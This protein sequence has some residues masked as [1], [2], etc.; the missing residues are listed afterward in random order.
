MFEFCTGN[1]AGEA[2]GQLGIGVYGKRWIERGKQLQVEFKYRSTVK[3][4]RVKVIRVKV[5]SRDE[6]QADACIR[7]WLSQQPKLTWLKKNKPSLATMFKQIV[8][9]DILQ[10]SYHDIHDLKKRKNFG[11]TSSRSSPAESS[12]ASIIKLKRARY[13][14]KKRSERQALK[15]KREMQVTCQSNN[16][17]LTLLGTV[18]NPF[19]HNISGRCKGH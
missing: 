14:T 16:H 7:Q 3:Q 17:N 15:H 10:R 12:P 5:P 19:A 1:N 8:D 11:R 4:K 9:K 6:D 2:F 18:P 13:A